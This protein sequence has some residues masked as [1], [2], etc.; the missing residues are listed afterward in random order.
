MASTNQ[1]LTPM[2]LTDA[3]RRNEF[4]KIVD[5]VSIN[6]KVKKVQSIIHAVSQQQQPPESRMASAPSAGE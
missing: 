1:Y 2:L 3:S 6:E 4:L 5:V